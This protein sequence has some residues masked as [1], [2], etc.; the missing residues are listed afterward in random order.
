M[1]N[2]D[3]SKINFIKYS[4]SKP[5]ERHI[6]NACCHDRIEIKG[7]NVYMYDKTTSGNVNFEME[8][9]MDDFIKLT[10]DLLDKLKRQSLINVDI[11]RILNCNNR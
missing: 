6:R 10:Y 11:L 5:L 3:L 1:E 4:D 8:C 7:G 9:S 2:L